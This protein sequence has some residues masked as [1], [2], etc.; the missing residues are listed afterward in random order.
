MEAAT[1]FPGRQTFHLAADEKDRQTIER[2]IDIYADGCPV[3]R[4]IKDSIE[5]TSELNLT[6]S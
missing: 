6:T 4:S 1:V 3:A 2:V 5:I